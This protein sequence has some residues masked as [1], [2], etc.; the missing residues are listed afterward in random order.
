MQVIAG[1]SEMKSQRALK[2]TGECRVQTGHVGN[3]YSYNNCSNMFRIFQKYR[4]SETLLFLQFQ[5]QLEKLSYHRF[6]STRMFYSTT[7]NTSN[8]KLQHKV[9]LKAS[10]DLNAGISYVIV[11]V[12]WKCQLKYHLPP[13]A[14]LICLF[15]SY[16]P[17]FPIQH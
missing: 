16:L 13:Q 7:T 11:P 5:E 12:I 6:W 4:V 3:N 2:S 14:M 17:I 15:K 10:V 1:V 8:N 9:F